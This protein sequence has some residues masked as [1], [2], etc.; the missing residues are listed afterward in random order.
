MPEPLTA[1]TKIGSS[2]VKSSFLLPSMF[3][4]NRKYSSPKSPTSCSCKTLSVIV[5]V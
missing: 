5:L 2:V 4:G 1:P 3:S